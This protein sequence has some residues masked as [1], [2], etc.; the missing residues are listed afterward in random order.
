MPFD[1]KSRE[2]DQPS[3]SGVTAMYTIDPTPEPLPA[4]R[5]MAWAIAGF[6]FVLGLI[7]ALALTQ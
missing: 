3:A 5:A 4:G 2:L 7:L 1:F 6:L